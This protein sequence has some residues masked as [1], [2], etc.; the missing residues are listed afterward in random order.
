MA[1]NFLQLDEKNDQALINFLNAQEK[2]GDT[3]VLQFGSHSLKFG[4][5]S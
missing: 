4:L 3:L 5:A 2:A 1:Q